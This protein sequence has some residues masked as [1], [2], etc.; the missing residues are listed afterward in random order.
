MNRSCGRGYN[1]PTVYL[2]VEK[3]IPDLFPRG[4]PQETPRVSWVDGHRIV[5]E[6]TCSTVCYTVTSSGCAL[7]TLT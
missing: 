3:V 5:L 2:S 7:A 6:Q 4:R 1:R